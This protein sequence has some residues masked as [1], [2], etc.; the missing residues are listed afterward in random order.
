MLSNKDSAIFLFAI[1]IFFYLFVLLASLQKIDT[2]MIFF[3]VTVW[4]KQWE[5]IGERCQNP[6]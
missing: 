3:S 5:A 6:K 2:A 1:F 4:A